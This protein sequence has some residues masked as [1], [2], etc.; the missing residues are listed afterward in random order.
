MEI[1]INETKDIAKT[2]S[3]TLQIAKTIKNT[4]GRS[5]LTRMAE[6]SI[7]QFPVLISSSIDTEKIITISRA[8]EKQ[9][10]SLMVTVLSMHNGVDLK[11]YDNLTNY[12][13]KFHSNK[14][15][16]SN[17]KAANTA[18][19]GTESIT[20][21]DE[22]IY[23]MEAVALACWDITEEQVNESVLNDIYKPYERTKKILEDRLSMAKVATEAINKDDL[24]QIADDLKRNE[25]VSEFGGFNK[26]TVQMRTMPAIVKNDRLTAMEPTL[27]NTQFVFYG[28]GS[29]QWTQNVVLGI[30]AMTRII[31]SDLMVSNMADAA[32][33]S[34]AIFKFI[35]WAKGEAKFVKDF[36]FKVGE[37]KDLATTSSKDGSRWIRAL[38]RRKAINN[39]SK[40]FDNKVLPNT[41]IIITSYE[42]MKIAELTGVDL[43][44][45][46]NA[47]NLIAKYYLLGFGIYDTETDILSMMFDD[48][49]ASFSQVTIS[50]LAS[51]NKKDVDLNNT[52]EVMKLMGRL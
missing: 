50:Q 39:V 30:K 32:K 41:T 16:P 37:V 11:K 36:I 38:K 28:E 3:S 23:G 10:A 19:F 7:F 29:K 9:Y 44:R 21:I 43:T 47:Y 22:H 14:D 18:I 4:M 27:I 17:I 15:I 49:N 46:D 1:N 33:N 24:I 31:R 26:D 13:K 40:F 25:K 48:S 34:N 2:I 8:L 20:T 52:R 12:V 42:A 51:N 6:D 35:K 45:E 5:S